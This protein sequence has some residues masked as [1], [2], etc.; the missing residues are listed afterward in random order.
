M[1]I[2]FDLDSLSWTDDLDH[3]FAEVDLDLGLDF[4]EPSAAQHQPGFGAVPL[5]FLFAEDESAFQMSDTHMHDM[6]TESN[7]DA[8]VLSP[9]NH[10]QSPDV[11][12]SQEASIEDPTPERLR[13]QLSLL[14]E[15]SCG[16]ELVFKNCDASK[17]VLL[18]R[19]AINFGLLYAHDSAHGEVSVTRSTNPN[20]A[21]MSFHSKAPSIVL[22]SP[23]EGLSFSSQV[24]LDTDNLLDGTLNILSP[25]IDS[26]QQLSRR[27][28]RSQRISD[29]ISKHV[30]T[31]KTSMSKG[32][33][34]RGPLTEDGRRDMK[35]LEGAGGACWRCKVLRRKV[36]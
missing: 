19:L 31:W 2:D 29:S 22:T 17:A 30:S 32:G 9:N 7:S 13:S 3:S 16:D 35:V 24:S 8:M 6:G 20:P 10:W 21:A 23:F 4:H 25:S 27:P 36:I 1:D 28:S 11:L 18:H 26:T 34:R 33:G 15:G 14:S 12:V 5:D